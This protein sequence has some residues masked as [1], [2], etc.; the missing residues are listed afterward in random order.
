MLSQCS[1]PTTR[2]MGLSAVVAIALVALT[3]CAAPTPEQPEPSAKLSLA[4][5]DLDSDGY[6]PDWSIGRAAGYCSGENRS[7]A[8][9]W[10]DA[11]A[12]TE[13]FVVTMTD[14]AHPSYVHWVVTGLDGELRSLDAADDGQPAVGVVGTSGA[15]SGSYVGPCL[16]DNT[17]VYTL[18]SLDQAVTGDSSTSLDEVSALMEGHVLATAELGVKRR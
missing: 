8:L 4:S 5:P 3:S 10:S 16:A 1:T 9:A 17:Y 18:Y 12:G 7:P 13:G 6:L 15:G 2:S 14:P 11:P